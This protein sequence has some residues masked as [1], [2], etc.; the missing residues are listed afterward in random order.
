MSSRTVHHLSTATTAWDAPD[1]RYPQNSCDLKKN[2]ESSPPSNKLKRND[3]E[4]AHERFMPLFSGAC[5]SRL[6]EQIECQHELFGT[7]DAARYLI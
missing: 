5:P 6:L 2:R 1:R 7:F 4:A 3:N